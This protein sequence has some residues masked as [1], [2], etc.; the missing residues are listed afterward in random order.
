MP[1]MSTEGTR[2]TD[3]H[4]RY[5]AERTTQEDAFLRDL[6]E[7]AAEAGIPAISIAPEQ[8]AFMGILLRLARAKRVVELGTLAGYSAISMAR[9]LPPEGRVL[10]IEVN[11]KHAAF[12][13]EW[14]AKSDVAGKVA[15]HLGAGA[16][17]LRTVPD[18]FA[19]ACFLDADKGS[20]R[21]YL[22][23]C[24]RILHPGGLVMA[25]NA[26]AF[27]QLLDESP[28]DADVPAVRAFNDYVPTVA[29]LE[30]V[31]VPLGDG[32]WVGVLRPPGP[33]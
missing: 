10:T 1:A 26:F 7:A 21:L 14:V 12:A 16:D 23:E 18:R 5:L 31:I 17:V 25:D 2:V 30:S 22:D 27:G 19:D 6:K 24:M 3:A 8:A 20:Y 13:K 29:G 33:L 15:V 4:F 11:P 32:L 9:A 28:T